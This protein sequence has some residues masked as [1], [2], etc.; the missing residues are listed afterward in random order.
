VHGLVMH[1]V[2]PHTLYALPQNGIFEGTFVP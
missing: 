2:R 1:P